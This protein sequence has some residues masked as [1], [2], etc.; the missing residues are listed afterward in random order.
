MEKRFVAVRRI[1][2][3][4]S[5]YWIA[6]VTAGTPVAHSLGRVTFRVSSFGS[7]TAVI[8]V[9]PSLNLNGWGRVAPE[10]R[11]VEVTRLDCASSVVANRIPRPTRRCRQCCRPS[12]PPVNGKV[13][14]PAS[15][16][17]R[18]RVVD[19][20]ST[21]KCIDFTEI[22]RRPSRRAGNHPVEQIVDPV[23][24]QLCFAFVANA[25]PH[26]HAGELG[27]YSPPR[28]TRHKPPL[29]IEPPVSVRH[30]ADSTGAEAL[31]DQRSTPA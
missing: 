10:G 21:L 9:Y 2:V 19:C 26:S 12:P 8:C 1:D 18:N 28:C 16:N 24:A 13:S 17:R 3:S 20:V 7:S 5:E 23:V 22:N 30:G 25:A 11:L 6:C 15:R 29:S 31:G 27:G 4:S 14:I